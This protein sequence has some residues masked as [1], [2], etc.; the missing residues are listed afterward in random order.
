M[1]KEDSF[2]KMMVNRKVKSTGGCLKSVHWFVK[3]LYTGEKFLS[4]ILQL[5]EKSLMGR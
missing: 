4:R 5:R 1:G 3:I 2:Y